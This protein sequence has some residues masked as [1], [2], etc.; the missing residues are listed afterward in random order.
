MTLYNWDKHYILFKV[1]AVV[2]L[3]VSSPNLHAKILT[4]KGDGI[5]WYLGGD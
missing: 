5:W 3:F 4:P 2:W 1:I